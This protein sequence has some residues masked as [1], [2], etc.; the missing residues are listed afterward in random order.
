MRRLD[1]HAADFAVAFDRLV[2]DR[3]ESDEDVARDVADILNEVKLRGDAAVAECGGRGDQRVPDARG[4][5]EA[6][7]GVSGG[8]QRL[9]FRRV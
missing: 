1:S 2:R 4:R 5:I 7:A 3:R 6:G 9:R 8:V